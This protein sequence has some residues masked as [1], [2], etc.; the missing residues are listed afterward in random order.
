[1]Q[2]ED[3]PDSVQGVYDELALLGKIFIKEI[4]QDLQPPT[5]NSMSREK[6]GKLLSMSP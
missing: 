2:L 6:K 3:G 4:N 1:L 5:S